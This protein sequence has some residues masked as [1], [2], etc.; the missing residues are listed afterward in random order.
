MLTTTHIRTTLTAAFL[1]ALSAPLHASYILASVNGGANGAVCGS[2]SP[3]DPGEPCAGSPNVPTVGIETQF[4]DAHGSY[5]ART[6]TGYGLNKIFTSSNSA[7]SGITANTE[8]MVV[9][10]LT[11]AAIGTQVDLIVDLGYEVSL[12]SSGGGEAGLRMV[13]N[14]QFFSHWTSTP[15]RIRLAPITASIVLDRRRSAPVRAP[16]AALSAVRSPRR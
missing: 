13:L 4:A 9:Y 6:L 8:W 14:G 12:T 3:I 7:T 2:V 5:D 16:I 11:G 1:F 10:T 15:Q